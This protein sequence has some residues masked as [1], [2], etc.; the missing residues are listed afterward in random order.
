MSDWNELDLPFREALI[1]AFDVDGLAQILR[2]SCEGRDL[3]Q[4]TGKNQARRKIV[5]DMIAQAVRDGWLDELAEGALAANPHTAKN[6][7]TS[8]SERP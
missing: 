7:R 6:H 5:D 8:A 3:E 2:Y 4:L 1:D